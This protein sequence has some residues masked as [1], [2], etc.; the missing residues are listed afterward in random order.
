MN[1]A[2]TVKIKKGRFMVGSADKDTYRG[3]EGVATS[4]ETDAYCIDRYEAPGKGHPPRVGASWHQAKAACE[5]RGMRL[6]ADAEWER[7][8]KG[9]RGLRYPY[10]NDFDAD[11]CVTEDRNEE[12]RTLHPS[13]SFTR[14]RS[15]YRVYD[16]SGNASEWTAEGHLRGG[17]ADKPDYAVR[18]AN[19][20]KKS[21]S[22]SGPFVGYRCCADAK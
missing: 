10:G 9:P 5:A 16:L 15:G 22:S 20:V 2:G 1:S 14:C 13:G 17:A 4:A 19:R 7:A 12:P 3:F 8:C 21:P 18:C 11:R 6:C